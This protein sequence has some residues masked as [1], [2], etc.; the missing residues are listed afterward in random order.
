MTLSRE[1]IREAIL[2]AVDAILIVVSF[3][4]ALSIANRDIADIHY[5]WFEYLWMCSAIV[6]IKRFVFNQTGLYKEIIRFASM[7]FVVII[8]KSTVFGPLISFKEVAP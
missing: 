7:P 3:V 6:A 5:R 2:T 8:V 4:L 1:H